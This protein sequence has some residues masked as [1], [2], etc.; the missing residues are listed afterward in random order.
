MLPMFFTTL[1]TFPSLG[2]NEATELAAAF[3]AVVVLVLITQKK[4][5]PAASKY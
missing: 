5:T 1:P 3:Q 4:K 2:G